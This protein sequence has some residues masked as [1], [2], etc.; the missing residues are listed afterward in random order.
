MYD[1]E[2][3]SDELLTL[4]NTEKE[5]DRPFTGCIPKQ[6]LYNEIREWDLIKGISEN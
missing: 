1:D 6:N 2:D 3:I 4:I 5:L